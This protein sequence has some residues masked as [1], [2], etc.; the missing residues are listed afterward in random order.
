MKEKV[1]DGMRRIILY[2]GVVFRDLS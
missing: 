2:T 1:L